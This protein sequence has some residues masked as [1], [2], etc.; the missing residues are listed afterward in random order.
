MLVFMRT[1]TAF[2]SKGVNV[3]T[4]VPVN[5]SGTRYAVNDKYFSFLFFVYY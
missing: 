4:V 3:D 1:M 5:P 2:Y